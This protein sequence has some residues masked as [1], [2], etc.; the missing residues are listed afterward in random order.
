MPGSSPE[1]AGSALLPAATAR[2][3][4]A[5]A[6]AADGGR[7]AR[8]RWR[9]RWRPFGALPIPIAVKL[10]IVI[11]A[12]GVAGMAALGLFMAEQQNRVMREQLHDF[13]GTAAAQLA[14]LA[15]EPILSESSL[16]LHMLTASLVRNGKVRG[17]AIYDHDGTLLSESGLQPPP[18][19]SRRS[20]ASAS[21]SQ[22]WFWSAPD[23]DERLVSFT[24][25]VDYREVRAGS[26]LV[27]L[28]A[29]LM[30]EAGAAA[31][32]V[33]ASA[34]AAMSLLATLI[35]WWMGRRMSRP[36]RSLMEATRAIDEGNFST[37]IN[38]RRSDE[39]GLL[40]EAINNMAEGLL[41]K[42]QVEQIFSRYVSKNVAD[43]VLANLDEVR[44]GSRHVEATVLFA[45]IVGF[46][47]MAERLAPRQV[48]ELLNEYFSYISTACHLYGGFVDKFIGD[49]AMLVF[50]AL[51]EN[52]PEHSFNAVCC[53]VLIQH[54]AAELNRRRRREGQPEVHFRIGINYGSMLAGNLG[55]DE[56]M[57]YTVVGDAVNL[58]SRLC[59]LARGGQIVIHEKLYRHLGESR[60]RAAAE[61]TLP[62]RG[63]SE[64]VTVYNVSD[65]HGKYH[66]MLKAHLE[67]VLASR[68]ARGGR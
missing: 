68:E 51:E 20:P 62:V 8:S 47:A 23:N 3:V 36:I 5:R 40:I 45:D 41:R 17:A 33:I 60:I 26:V 46:T 58:A 39:I 43:K 49:C 32:R 63:R 30:D 11:A 24:A 66:S 59:C 4:S 35:A 57:E 7:T 21:T 2:P 44:L 27:T 52:D 9:G 14:E 37:R 55:S 56:R 50:G 18:D 61:Q 10:A 28:S 1:A 31:R 54:M 67:E 6:E 16:D 13:G 64:P 48:S 38:E 12:L 25:P 42:S 65:V 19:S 34:T 22:S 53:A 15:S 29:S